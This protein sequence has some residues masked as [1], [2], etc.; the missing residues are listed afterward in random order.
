MPRLQAVNTSNKEDT[1]NDLKLEIGIAIYE[2]NNNAEIPNRTDF[3]RIELWMEFK[4]KVQGPAFCDPRDSG[5]HHRANKVEAFVPNT[6]EGSKT[7][8]QMTHYASAHHSLQFRHFSFSILVEDN[9]ARFLRWDRAGTVVTA[10]F[11]YREKPELMA[12]FF[13][14]FHGMSPAERGR[15][16]SVRLAKQLPEDDMRVRERLGIKDGIPLYEYTIPSLE[17][18][19]YAYGPRPPATNHLLASRFSRTTPAVWVP[20]VAGNGASESR[21]KPE[22]FSE[23][24]AKPGE[25]PWRAERLVFLKD[26]WRH[27]SRPGVEVMPE[28][29]IYEILHKNGTPNIPDLVA[30]GDVACGK[31]RTHEFTSMKWLRMKPGAWPFQHYRLALG[32]VGRAL[33][34]FDC[35]KQ[36]VTGVLDALK[37]AFTLIFNQQYVDFQVQSSFARIRSRETFAP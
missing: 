32:V 36:L 25:R 20:A 17:E 16:E 23:R 5:A 3:S 15:D 8:G 14:R 37:G 1:G 33:F 10:A 26:T 30:G 11:D 12:E 29:E 13:C 28:H 35:T 24:C 6:V 21:T 9:Y 19:G 34:K 31:T 22:S 4:T 2:P 7:R 18:M 27:L